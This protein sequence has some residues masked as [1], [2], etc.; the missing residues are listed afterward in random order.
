MDNNPTNRK[1]YSFKEIDAMKLVEYR[2]D[3]NKYYTNFR[4]NGKRVKQATKYTSK[5]DF[6]AAHAFA[7]NLRYDL[8]RGYANNKLRK[9]ISFKSLL[10]GYISEKYSKGTARNKKPDE[11]FEDYLKSIETSN[12]LLEFYK[13][14]KTRDINK[15]DWKD[16]R[17][18]LVRRWKSGG[19]KPVTVNRKLALLQ[20]ILNYGK[21]QDF[22]DPV[23]IKMLPYTRTEK[24]NPKTEEEL[25]TQLYKYLPPHLKDPFEFS[26]RTGVRK[27]N[28][29]NL[30]RHH[31]IMG[32]TTL[33]IK[34]DEQKGVRDIKQPLSKDMRKL[35]KRN[36]DVNSKYV[37]KGYRGKEKLGNF[38]KAWLNAKK[39]AGITDF[40][41]HDIR[42]SLGYDM[43]AKGYTLIDIRDKFGHSD[44]RM[45]ERYSRTNM[46]TQAREAN[47]RDDDISRFKELAVPPTVP[48]RNLKSDTLAP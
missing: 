24:A 12:R 13:S 16:E 48:P 20:S 21:D 11:T 7:V 36:I 22:C 31:I 19:N 44:I 10:E 5:D 26:W 35:L 2:A 14:F 30:T 34:G 38:K 47:S 28:L 3:K 15:I 8:E 18:I 33:F 29:V 32:G 1:L 25:F 17:G 39:K 46:E 6:E 27:G 37:F 43:N 40:R 42:H 41:W 23:D 9:R 4:F 45:T